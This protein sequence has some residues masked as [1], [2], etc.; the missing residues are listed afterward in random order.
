ME[1]T[2]TCPTCGHQTTYRPDECV[3]VVRFK[4]G[5]GLV[6]SRYLLA[7]CAGCGKEYDV[8]EEKTRKAGPHARPAG[9]R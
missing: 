8:P 1:R 9:R 3:V 6:G 7:R 5:G 2:C 4:P